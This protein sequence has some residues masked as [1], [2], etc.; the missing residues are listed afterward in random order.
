MQTCKIGKLKNCKVAK[1]KKNIKIQT[2][3]IVNVHKLKN[4]N[5]KSKNYKNMHTCRSCKI[6]KMKMKQKL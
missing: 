4:E 3:K 6:E 5:T 2:C 1:N